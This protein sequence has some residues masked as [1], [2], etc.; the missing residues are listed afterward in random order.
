MAAPTDPVHDPVFRALTLILAAAVVVLLAFD[1]ISHQTG[2][3]RA[4]DSLRHAVPQPR[5]GSSRTSRRRGTSS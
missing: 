2:V 4:V 5:V 3:S 1:A